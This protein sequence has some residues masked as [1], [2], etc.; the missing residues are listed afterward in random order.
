MKVLSY[1]LRNFDI[2]SYTI[3]R[4]HFSFISS[5]FILDRQ[6]TRTALRINRWTS[7]I[8]LLLIIGGILLFA[9][10]VGLATISSLPKYQSEF[11]KKN[12]ETSANQSS[13]TVPDWLIKLG[14]IGTQV[15]GALLLLM[16]VASFIV[17]WAMRGSMGWAWT[18]ALI[19]SVIS[20]VYC[21]VTIFFGIIT[22][23]PY[24]RLPNDRWVGLVVYGLAIF[25]LSRPNVRL[26]YASIKETSASSKAQVNSI[27]SFEIQKPEMQNNAE[28]RTMFSIDREELKTNLSTRIFIC[29]F[30][31]VATFFAAMVIVPL[32]IAHRMY[33]ISIILWIIV[34]YLSWYSSSDGFVRKNKI[35]IID[36]NEFPILH[37]IIQKLTGRINIPEPRIG[38]M[39]I[40]SPDAFTVGRNKDN[41][42]IVVC[43]GLL[44]IL[45]ESEIEAVIAHEL[46]HVINGDY[47]VMTWAKMGNL[48]GIQN[49]FTYPLSKY[50]EFAAD[51]VGIKVIGRAK[52]MIS[53]LLKI[54]SWLPDERTKAGIFDKYPAT[55]ER[56]ERIR[57]LEMRVNKRSG[58]N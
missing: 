19:I 16:G 21:I 10:G 39:D 45:D 38:I 11:I 44:K 23:A 9:Q 31:I 42:T 52:Y 12:S 36:K 49:L 5:I 24:E 53:A 17:G 20:V 26:Y 58:G 6:I 32:I 56:I 2:K 41:C 51:E 28:E 3:F 7:I 22:N 50:K 55:G 29:Y 30:G 35:K 40:N 57:I 27:Q 18:A 34:T 25:C 15:I 8:L 1:V 37:E 4:Y 33:P 14:P 43:T 47:S 46:G 13:T 54:D 48:F